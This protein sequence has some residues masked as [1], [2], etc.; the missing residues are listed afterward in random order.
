[1]IKVIATTSFPSKAPTTKQ[2]ERESQV[3]ECL[4]SL[5][6]NTKILIIEQCERITNYEFYICLNK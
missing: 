4:S 6:K 5:H 2:R 3:C 1:M